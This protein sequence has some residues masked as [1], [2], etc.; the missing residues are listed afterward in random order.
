MCYCPFWK[1]SKSGLIAAHGTVRFNNSNAT[2]FGS[3]LEEGL[4]STQKVTEFGAQIRYD[5]GLNLPGPAGWLQILA[6]G[7]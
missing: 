5:C 4:D 3:I 7:F 2:L 1:R 6:W